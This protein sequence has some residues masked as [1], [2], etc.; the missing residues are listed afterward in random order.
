MDDS[1]DD[2][3]KEFGATL[4]A[5]ADANGHGGVAQYF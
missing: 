2:A 1:D 3:N 5:V 4:A